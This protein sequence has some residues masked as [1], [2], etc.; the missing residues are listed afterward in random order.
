MALWLYEPVLVAG[1][2]RSWR[3]LWGRNVAVVSL[4]IFV[5]LF[6]LIFYWWGRPSAAIHSF[7]FQ[8]PTVGRASSTQ[9]YNPGLPKQHSYLSHPCSFLWSTGVGSW[10]CIEPCSES[11][12]SGVRHGHLVF[13]KALI[14]WKADWQKA[15][16]RKRESLTCI[17]LLP[18]W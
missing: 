7:T 11:R 2:L 12:Y 15:R 9:D 13:R 14:I 3:Q 5:G 4:S 18:K 10:S 1:Y 16:L 8:M 17:I 6:F